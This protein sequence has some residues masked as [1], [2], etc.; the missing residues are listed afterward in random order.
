MADDSFFSRW[1]RRK[2]A[3][4]QGIE[5]PEPEPVRPTVPPPAATAAPAVLADAQATL[6]AQD[7]PPTLTLD[8]VARL[9]PSDDFAPFVARG[10]SPEVKAAAMKKLFADP[11]YNI[12]DGLDIYIDDYTKA[13]PIPLAML[14]QLHQSKMLR[15][16]E[17]DDDSA[18]STERT[19]VSD[20]G[21]P[22]T[23]TQMVQPEMADGES[24][25]GQGVASEGQSDA[26]AVTV[27]QAESPQLSERYER[28]S[29]TDDSGRAIIGHPA[30]NQPSG[31]R[32]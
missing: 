15:L 31:N 18:D 16:F 6:V 32:A 11:H 1:A 21:P 4:R 23:A 22:D 26:A 17:S 20:P 30:P 7:E 27:S 8:D 25:S 5:L 28:E 24:E 3:D 12:M 19:T 9:L 13:D 2:A 10:V 29:T 14:Q